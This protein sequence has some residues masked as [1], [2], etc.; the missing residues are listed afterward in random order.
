V[1]VQILLNTLVSAAAGVLVAV[2]FTVIYST[3]RFFNFA[4]GAIFTAGAYILY[5]LIA[6]CEWPTW[7]AIP[8]A[9]TAAALLGMGLD[10]GIYRPL[11]RK[12]A[13][14]LVLLIASLGAFV[15]I[16]N[17]IVLLFGDGTKTLRAADPTEG[18][19]ILGGRIT[20]IQGLTVIGS[21]V[22]CIA[23][24]LVLRFSR[25]GRTMRAVANDA[26]LAKCVGIESD[27]VI[28]VSFG[29]GSA[30][31]AVAAILIGYDTDLSPAM[32]FSGLLSGVVA[33]I[34]GGVGS[35]PGAALGALLV[36][37]AQNFGVWMLPSQ[38]QDAIVFVILILFLLLRPQ[39]M[40]GT[41]LKKAVV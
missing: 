33:A 16:Q 32:G 40:L 29:A 17:V 14:E 9:V 2:G 4:H 12:G 41:P 11:R 27:R 7:V 34:I 15:V 24:W 30:L 37:T 35:I 6:I 25:T 23:T 10:L 8:V 38:W 22:L 5:A 28:L 21:V 13:S 3:A 18:L 20:P 1:L 26:E 39:G 19:Y 36:S 31:A